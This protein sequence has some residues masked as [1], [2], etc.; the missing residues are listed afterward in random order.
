MPAWMYLEGGG[1]RLD[2]T[3]HRRWGKDDVSL[4]W[5]AVASQQKVGTYWHMLPEAAQARKA[6]WDAINPRTGKRRIDEAFPKEIIKSK[7]EQDMMITFKNGST[8]Q[9]L[10]SDN[11]DSYVGSPPVGV[12]FSEWSLARPAAWAYVRPILLENGGWSIFIWTPRGRNH[13]TRSFEARERDPR[14]FTGR[15]PACHIDASTYSSAIKAL[16]DPKLVMNTSVFTAEQLMQELKE[17]VE[18]SGSEQEG[19][20]KFCSE[21]LVNFDAAAPGA[22]YATELQTLITAGRRTYVPHN[23]EMLVDTAWDLGIDDYTTIWFFQRYK[24]RIDIIDYYETGDAGLDTIVKEAFKNER[25]LAYSY[26]MHYLPHD[27]MVRELGASGKTRKATLHSL[28][29]KTIRVGIAR[30]P[31][32]RISA[33]RRL[34]PFVRFDEKHT[35]V[36][37]DHL[38]MY[39]KK[40]N[41]S[42]GVFVGP[43]HNEDSHAADSMGELAINARL[44]AMPKPDEKPEVEDR[45]AKLFREAKRAPQS[46][47]VL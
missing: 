41:Q 20:S 15:V 42:M 34:L 40:F 22:Y 2:L 6:I 11:Y 4:H 7:R 35:Q 43:L 14:W 29:L 47:K 31:E 17:M 24:D 27:V 1:K 23:P 45:W 36:G 32:E 33:V 13:A 26:G 12:V 25:A 37:F 21:Y 8:W 5:A 44:K 16:S 9:V 19:L 30:N 18:E 46:W 38:K 10:G 39:R 28:G 3:A